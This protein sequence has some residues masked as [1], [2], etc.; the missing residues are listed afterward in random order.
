M[1]YDE[2]RCHAVGVRGA[3][4]DTRCRDRGNRKYFIIHKQKLRSKLKKTISSPQRDLHSNKHVII[5]AGQ[6]SS[7]HLSS[8]E[9]N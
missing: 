3:Q 6:K 5:Y 9:A 4:K 8:I 2:V 7:P 1:Q